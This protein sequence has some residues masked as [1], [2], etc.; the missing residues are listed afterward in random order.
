MT[1]LELGDINLVLEKVCAYY[2]MER[3][4]PPG[5]EV[6]NSNIKSIK[7]LLEGGHSLEIHGRGTVISFLKAMRKLSQTST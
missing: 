3:P 1:L 4:L 7:I 5:G 6:D 2:Y